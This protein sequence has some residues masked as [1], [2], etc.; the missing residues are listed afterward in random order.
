MISSAGRWRNTMTFQEALEK[1]WAV[2]WH[3]RDGHG[4]LEI[5]PLATV[6]DRNGKWLQ[7][8]EAERKGKV[9]MVLGVFRDLETATSGRREIKR[10]LLQGRGEGLL[11]IGGIGQRQNA[12][13]D[14]R[15]L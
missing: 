2:E 14:G 8:P 6:V 9:P 11:G 15:E 10:R 7:T 3:E 5:Y 4:A 12:G 1:C 13:G